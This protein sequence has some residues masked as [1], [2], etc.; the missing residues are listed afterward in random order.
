MQKIT[1]ASLT[2]ALSMALGACTTWAAVPATNICGSAVHHIDVADGEMVPYIASI[3][4]NGGTESTPEWNNLHAETS[5][6]I[7]ILC[8]DTMKGEPRPV[9]LPASANNCVLQDKNMLCR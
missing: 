2:V 1:F 5:A 4:P 9:P 6:P 3:H 7:T 8:Y